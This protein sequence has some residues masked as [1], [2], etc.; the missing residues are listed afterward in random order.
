MVFATT[1][2]SIYYSIYYPFY[3]KLGPNKLDPFNRCIYMLIILLPVIIQRIIDVLNIS[4]SKKDFYGQINV[5]QSKFLW[6]TLF[7]IIML[8]IS[9]YISII[10]HKNK[11]IMY[12]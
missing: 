9:A 12:E 11:A 4:I 6:I 10:I 3:F 2:V 7:E 8:T 1:L 5:I